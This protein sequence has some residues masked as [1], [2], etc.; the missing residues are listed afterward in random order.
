MKLQTWVDDYFFRALD[1]VLEQQ[2]AVIETTKAGVINNALSHLVG[3]SSKSEFAAAAV[4]GFGSNM[5][6]EKR[7]ELAKLLYSWTNEIPA[8]HRR[9]LDGYYDKKTG[10]Q[11][12]YTLDESA[13]PTFEDLMSEEGPMVRTA[14]VQRDEMMMLPWMA[15]MEPFILV[16]PEGCGK[17]MLL[18]K[19]FSAHRGTQVAVVHCS[20]QTLA[21]H[22]I[23]KLASVCQVIERGRGRG[24]WL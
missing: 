3:V 16:G 14:A 23:H 1:W 6:L 11:V 8:D 20:A 12:L 22:V 19:L 13:P 24:G 9:P 10:D 18:S 4:R 7:A 15:N 21:S 17:N 5:V 2:A